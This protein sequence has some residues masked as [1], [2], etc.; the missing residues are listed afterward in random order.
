MRAF[1]GIGERQLYGCPV[2][3]RSKGVRQIRQRALSSHYVE[4]DMRQVWANYSHSLMSAVE[5]RRSRV[6]GPETPVQVS[7]HAYRLQ[8]PSNPKTPNFGE[9]VAVGSACRILLHW[10]ALASS[11]GLQVLQ[12]ATQ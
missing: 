2:R 12:Q 5:I 7:P 1:A 11:I 6:F 10:V 9:A 8:I 3:G 4:T